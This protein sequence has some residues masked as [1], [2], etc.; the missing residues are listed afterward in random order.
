MARAERYPV[1]PYPKKRPLYGFCAP[2]RIIRVRDGDTVEISIAQSTWVW[3]LR[4]LDCWTPEK[5]R[6]TEKTAGLAA[7]QYA[8]QLCAKA[9]KPSVFVP[10]TRH[11]AN[12]L[13]F[14]TFDRVPAVLY[15]DDRHTLNGEMVRAGYA[16]ETK[17]AQKRLKFDRKGLPSRAN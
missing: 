16:A 10:F 9:K 5:N 13:K 11:L 15:L 2:C 3:A 14:V 6:A 1:I 12:P 8:I 17:E 7:K 4:L